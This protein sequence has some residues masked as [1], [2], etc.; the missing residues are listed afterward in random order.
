MSSSTGNRA[1]AYFFC[2]DDQ[3]QAQGPGHGFLTGDAGE[4]AAPAT[5]TNPTHQLQAHNAMGCMSPAHRVFGTD[6]CP[7]RQQ[8]LLRRGGRG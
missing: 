8:G 4:P 3:R 5:Q 1:T 7:L 6:G 2:R